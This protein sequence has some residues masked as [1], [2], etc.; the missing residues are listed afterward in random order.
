MMDT[1]KLDMIFFMTTENG[2][3]LT[4]EEIQ[5]IAKKYLGNEFLEQF[6]INDNNMVF[7]SVQNYIDGLQKDLMRMRLGYSVQ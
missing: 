6:H 3:N 4:Y 1:R 2:K 5:D 7:E